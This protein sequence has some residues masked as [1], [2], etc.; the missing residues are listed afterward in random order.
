MKRK[1]GSEEAGGND[2]RV[3]VRL[4]NQTA[5][6]LHQSLWTLLRFRLPDQEAMARTAQERSRRSPSDRHTTW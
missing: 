2:K 6:A 1:A 3:K 4:I 5:K